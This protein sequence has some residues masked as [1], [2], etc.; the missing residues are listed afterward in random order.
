MTAAR[1]LTVHA[2]RLTAL[3]G[4]PVRAVTLL[5]PNFNQDAI[6]AVIPT[7]HP[8]CGCLLIYWWACFISRA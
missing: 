5:T 4:A 1:M 8:L 6:V 7:I 3:S 2:S